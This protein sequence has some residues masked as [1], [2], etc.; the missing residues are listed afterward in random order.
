MNINKEEQL[1]NG[2]YK[3]F[4]QMEIQLDSLLEEKIFLKDNAFLQNKFHR[5]NEIIYAG[6]K[7]EFNEQV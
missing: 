3:C 6:L 2:V 1:S 7:E 5:L 4:L